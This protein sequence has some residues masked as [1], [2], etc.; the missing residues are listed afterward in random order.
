MSPMKALHTDPLS[1]G[2]EPV[3]KRFSLLAQ[4]FTT[5]KCV[6]LADASSPMCAKRIEACTH[7][8]VLSERAQ[9]QGGA[10]KHTQRNVS[11]CV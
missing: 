5:Q 10:H 2:S 4:C 6:H 9:A 8:D 1:L 7:I 3:T 11:L